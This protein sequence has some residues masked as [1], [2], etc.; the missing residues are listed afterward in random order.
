[1][2]LHR[3]LVYLPALLRHIGVHHFAVKRRDGGGE[4][5]GDYGGKDAVD[6][7]LEELEKLLEKN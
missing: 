7:V 4:R 6:I 1:M 2:G 3:I 5:A